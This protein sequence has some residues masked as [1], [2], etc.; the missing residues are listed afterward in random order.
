MAAK[1]VRWAWERAIREAALMPMTKAVALMLATY[2]D[3]KGNAH[4]STETLARNLGIEPSTTRTHLL[5]LERAV[6]LISEREARQGSG[7]TR[8]RFRATVPFESMLPP[9]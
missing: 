1:S 3:S 7:Q 9:Q 8:V 4:P 5:A 6:F 2:M